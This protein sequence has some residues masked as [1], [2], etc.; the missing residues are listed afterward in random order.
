LTSG[1]TNSV[2]YAPAASFT[3]PVGGDTL[4]A[5]WLADDKY[6]LDYDGNGE[7]GGTEPADSAEVY[8]GVDV[9]V[10]GPSDLAKTDHT[11][12]GWS[13]TSGDT[14]SVDYAPA[15]SFTMPVGGDTLYAVWELTP[16][17]GVD[18]FKTANVSSVMYGDTITYTIYVTNTGNVPIWGVYADAMLSIEANFSLNPGE[19]TTPIVKTYITDSSDV[20][21]VVN[22]A[23]VYL[24]QEVIH[25]ELGEPDA[26]ATVTVLVNELPPPPTPTPPP[27]PPVLVPNISVTITPDETLVEVGTEVNFTMV[28]TNTGQSVLMDVVVDNPDL[29]FTTTIPILYVMGSETFG[30]PKILNDLGDF[31]STVTA[32]GNSTG[33]AVTSVSD[34]DVTVVEVYE[35]IIPPPPTPPPLDPP[36]NPETGAIPFDAYAVSGLL[37]MGAGLFALVS[38]KKEENEE[39]ED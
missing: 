30:A 7:T 33:T 26:S 18:I 34:T 5:V 3:M 22:T 15:A 32:T 6:V 9:T 14:N 20:P 28:V 31:T 21:Q 2:D 25:V 11:F 19:S 35:M 36:D 24:N 1:D 29:G 37:A 17:T 8:A 10:S 38:R 4:Y 16:I 12:Q 23:V 27:P 39:D 13:L